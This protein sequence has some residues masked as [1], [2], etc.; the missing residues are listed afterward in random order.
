MEQHQQPPGST[1]DRM[2]SLGYSSTD[3]STSEVNLSKENDADD[4]KSIVAES[5]TSSAT[6]DLD[7]HLS[8]NDK[9][10]GVPKLDPEEEVTTHTETTPVESLVAMTYAS[11]ATTTITTTKRSAPPVVITPTENGDVIV[12]KPI[13]MVE[14]GRKLIATPPPTDEEETVQEGGSR[15]KQGGAV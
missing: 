6:I 11:Y 3:I 14:V 4:E 12:V 5:S 2:S 1:F 10:L 8:T 9:W 15:T 13:M 7:S